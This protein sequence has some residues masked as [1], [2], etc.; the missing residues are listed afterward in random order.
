M[1]STR[2]GALLAALLASTAVS[3]AD[4]TPVTAP[5]SEQQSLRAVRDKETG[6]LRAPNESELKQ[7][8]EAER[9]SRRARGL[10]EPEA[11][12]PTVVRLHGNG[13]RSARLGPEHLISIHAQRS[14]DGRLIQSHA[15][16]ANAHPTPAQKELPTE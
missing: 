14:P 10:P 16:P 2:T 15:N 3:A 7:L 11:A 5:A 8:I 12:A 1:I 9:A 6:K 13:M 4:V